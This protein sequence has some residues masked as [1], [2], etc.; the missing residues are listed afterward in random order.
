M[1]NVSAQARE[2]W[3][4]ARGDPDDLRTVRGIATSVMLGTVLWSVIIMSVLLSSR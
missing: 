4:T 1:S 3:T 2:D